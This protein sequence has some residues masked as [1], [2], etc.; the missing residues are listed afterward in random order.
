MAKENPGAIASV[1][2]SPVLKS[3][4]NPPYSSAI[5]SPQRPSSADFSNRLAI[6]SRSLDASGS[7]GK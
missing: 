7:C 1:N 2:S 5:D 3:R 4:S 6:N